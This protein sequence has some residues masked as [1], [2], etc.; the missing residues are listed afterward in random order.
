MTKRLITFS[1]EGKMSTIA[2]FFIFLKMSEFIKDEEGKRIKSKQ[3]ID[4][5]A[6]SN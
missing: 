6:S 3:S 4:N 2:L 1:V 5:I